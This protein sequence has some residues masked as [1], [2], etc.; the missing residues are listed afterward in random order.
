L[1]RD[2]SRTAVRRG[3]VARVSFDPAG[4]EERR[5]MRM[6]GT[7]QSE[8]DAATFQDYLLTCEIK[9][10]VE[11]DGAA[12]WAIWVYDEDQLE[13]AKAELAE[14]TKSPAEPRYRETAARAQ[15]LRKQAEA[16]QKAARKRQVVVRERWDRPL[17]SRAPVTMLLI[18][19]S[20]VVTF[21]GSTLENGWNLGDKP[22]PL[23]VH[24][25][26]APYEI[27][28]GM[29]RWEGGLPNILRGEVWRLVTPIFIHFSLFHILFNML[30]LR[31]LGAVIEARYGSLRLLLLTLF[32]AIAANF[33][34][35]LWNGPAFGGMSGVVFGLFGFI[36]MKGKYDP[37][38]GLFM[39]PN[40]VFMMMVWMF[41]CMTGLAGSIANANHIVGLVAGAMIGYLPVIWRRMR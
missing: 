6:I 3:R 33:A 8:Q 19:A 27:G 9:S 41:F 26:F 13:T 31:D 36:W 30:W 22:E 5:S 29:I 2:A 38:S 37:E 35:Y 32:I 28:G 4:F 15:R 10:Q 23:L 12:R 1:C 21:L 25:Y 17:A 14:F 39:P 40:M 24:L 34:Q 18:A 20:V 11:P 16:E 7:V